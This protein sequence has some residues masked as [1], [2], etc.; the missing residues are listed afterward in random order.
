MMNTTL[1][2]QIPSPSL[3]YTTTETMMPHKGKWWDAEQK[4]TRKERK[5]RAKWE[6]LALRLVPSSLSSHLLALTSQFLLESRSNLR[7][8][9]QHASNLTT[10]LPLDGTVSTDDIAL[11]QQIHN[12]STGTVDPGVLAEVVGARELLATLTARE[13]LV[14]CVK[15]SEVSLQVLLTTEPSAARWNVADEGLW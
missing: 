8:G 5:E 1:K 9:H 4:E 6:C 11:F 2:K 12:D 13:W 10:I 7:W 15:G 3:Y 14:L